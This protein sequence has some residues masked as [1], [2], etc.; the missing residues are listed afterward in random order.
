MDTIRGIVAIGSILLLCPGARLD[1]QSVAGASFVVA[2]YKTGSTVSLYA[3]RRVGAGMIVGG[4]VGNPRSK[5]RTAV[6]GV[7]TLVRLTPAAS[8]IVIVG[9]AT[10][11]D[12][13]SL[14]FFVL[15]KVTEGRLVLR[16]TAA[17]YQPV[18]GT[19]AR[20]AAL[21][22]LTVSVR[23]A[24]RVQAGIAAVA[25][26]R[27]GRGPEVGAGPSVRIPAPGGALSIE[28]V[29][30]RSRPLAARVGFSAWRR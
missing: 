26:V 4:L 24:G 25:T 9:G 20:L 17:C 12:G 28:L 27:A 15:P 29:A 16:A 8:A 6:V 2:Q 21:D 5:A 30:R 23:V 1:A 11:S 13:E 19:G 22:P 18:S 14:R 3:A 10:G 7:G